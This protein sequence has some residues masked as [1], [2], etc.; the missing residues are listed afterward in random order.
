M[1]TGEIVFLISG[2]VI[3][4]ALALISARNNKRNGYYFW[5]TFFLGFG[6]LLAITLAAWAYF[7]LRWTR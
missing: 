5:R 6:G 2:F 4:L 7:F 1:K 3:S